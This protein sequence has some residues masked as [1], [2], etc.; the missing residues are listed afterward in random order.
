MRHVL[1]LLLAALALCGTALAAT[2]Q[3][4]SHP[5]FSVPFVENNYG[6]ALAEAQERKVP[7][8]VDNW[9]PW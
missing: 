8:F 9:A 4:A 1:V 3:A 2:P 7:L 5:K 6:R